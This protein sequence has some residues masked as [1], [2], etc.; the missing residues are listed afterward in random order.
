MFQIE[1]MWLSLSVRRA[2]S[3][4]TA[5]SVN[6]KINKGNIEVV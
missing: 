6:M 1:E 5:K 4:T 2:T 3:M